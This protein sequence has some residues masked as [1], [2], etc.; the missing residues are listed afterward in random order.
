MTAP[1]PAQAVPVP[2]E[3]AGGDD[4]PSPLTDAYRA[5]EGLVPDDLGGPAN[6]L[7]YMHAEYGPDRN[8]SA[9][10]AVVRPTGELDIMGPTGHVILAS[11]TW[12]ECRYMFAAEPEPEPETPPQA[13]AVPAE[14]YPPAG[15]AIR[16]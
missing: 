14:L 8:F 4:Y 16:P 2:S 13:A 9:D 11:R 7:V 12:V 3:P 10:E 5:A 6:V 1:E 15:V